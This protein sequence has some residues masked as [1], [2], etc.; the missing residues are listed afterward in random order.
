MALPSALP[1]GCCPRVSADLR[2]TEG[3]GV[4]TTASLGSQASSS[5]NP[6]V[7][8]C[9]PPGDRG[10]QS[11]TCF[12]SLAHLP[13]REPPRGTRPPSADSASPIGGMPR[14][15]SVHLSGGGKQHTDTQN[16][17][18]ARA[19]CPREALLSGAVFLFW[20][21]VGS[22]TRNYNSSNSKREQHNLNCPYFRPSPNLVEPPTR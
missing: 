11:T 13:A 3:R 17:R 16:D 5:G 22:Q 12:S 9:R 6:G 2:L 10:A 1:H 8:I 21:S 20:L 7:R 18:Q 15:G 19:P 4:I 14:A